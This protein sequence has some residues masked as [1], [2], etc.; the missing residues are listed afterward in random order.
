MTTQL[1]LINIII[2]IIIIIIILWNPKAH[3]CIHKIPLIFPV[4]SQTNPVH[5]FP[6]NKIFFY[7]L[8]SDSL[9][10]VSILY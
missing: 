2:I 10:A 3:N 5:A 8:I 6:T 7:S 4:V 1:Q 9:I